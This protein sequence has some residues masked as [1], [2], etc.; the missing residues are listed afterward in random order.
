MSYLDNLY[1]EKRHYE[2]LKS[3]VNDIV[4]RMNTAIMDLEHPIVNL[5]NG[6]KIDNSSP[7]T[8]KL[9][10][11]K[12]NLQARKEYLSNNVIS[13]INSS[14]SHIESEIRKEEQRIRE[15]EERLERER[16]LAL[17]KAKEELL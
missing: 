7:G 1:T 15:E 13:S 12:N 3:D 14:I 10:N 17:E 16:M 8:T 5:E 9:K 2:N 11:I 4:S 6:F